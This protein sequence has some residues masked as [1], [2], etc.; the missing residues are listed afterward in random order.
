MLVGND[1]GFEQ[2]F[3]RQIEAVGRK[4]DV[5][6]GITT[7]GRS[8]NIIRAFEVAKAMG[9]VTVAFTG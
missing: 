4:S 9:L 2:V 7:S 6:I 8:P 3:S 1:L 5:A